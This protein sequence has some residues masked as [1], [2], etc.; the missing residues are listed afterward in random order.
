MDWVGETAFVRSAGGSLER[1][2]LLRSCPDISNGE[3]IFCVDNNTAYG[4]FLVPGVEYTLT[5]Q[6][7][8]RVIKVKTRRWIDGR[9]TH[10]LPI[11]Q[12]TGF[13]AEDYP[14]NILREIIVKSQDEYLL[15]ISR[16]ALFWSR[17]FELGLFALDSEDGVVVVPDPTLKFCFNLTRDV[18]WKVRDKWSDDFEFR[19]SNKI[20][21]VAEGIRLCR[22]WHASHKT[23]S[24]WITNRFMENIVEISRV[25][26]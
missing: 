1:I 5:V 9:P 17:L 14:K 22:D 13:V 18:R 4:L 25:S 10:L 21:E 11:E 2:S 23:G 26:P 3:E 8:D 7:S 12:L 15:S 24:T 6:P 19:A 16:S 20:R